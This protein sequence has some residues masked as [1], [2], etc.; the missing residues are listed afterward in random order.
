V[1][2]IALNYEIPNI[3]MMEERETIISK[4]KVISQFEIIVDYCA[5]TD[6]RGFEYKEGIHAFWCPTPF[7][8]KTKTKTKTKTQIKSIL[9]QSNGVHPKK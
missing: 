9:S 1:F 5:L 4:C 8:L 7:S 6:T 3:A 2:I